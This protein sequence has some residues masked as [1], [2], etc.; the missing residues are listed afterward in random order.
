MDVTA[1]TPVIECPDI[2]AL[3]TTEHAVHLIVGIDGNW[4][5][6]R[7]ALS[8]EVLRKTQAATAYAASAAFR[9]R[10]FPRIGVVRVKTS[11]EAPSIVA[12][13]LAEQGIELENLGAA[14]PQD[15]PSCIF[16]GREQLSSEQA[17]MTDRGTACPSC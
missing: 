11:T 17:T 6:E 13:L 2:A 12:H 8:A 1:E 16:C 3:I 14:R 9:K 15:G 5:T 7:E 4:E 10:F